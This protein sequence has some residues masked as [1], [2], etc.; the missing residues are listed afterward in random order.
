TRRQGVELMGSARWGSLMLTLRYNHIDATFRSSY[1][2]ASPNNSTADADGA[3]TVEPGDRIPGIP[4]DSAKLRADW[5]IDE[6]WS[7]GATVVY[8]SSQYAHGDENN[9]D[10]HG[11]VPGYAF[12]NL[13]A[14][15]RL[16]KELL[17]FANVTNVFDRR[18]QNFGL[19]GANAFTGPD[20]TFGPALGIAP[21]PEQFRGL[22]APR[23]YWI[24]LRYTFGNTRRA[25]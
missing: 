13:D 16:S 5:D 22:G 11:T 2:A 7:F 8:A 14:Q 19:L 21:E 1:K 23:G 4:A 6:R 9:Q 17:L 20:R 12:A 15:F 10:S 3:I 24:G 18:Y 25:D